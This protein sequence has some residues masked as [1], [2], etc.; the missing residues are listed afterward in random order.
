MVQT[1]APAKFGS[2]SPVEHDL[3]LPHALVAHWLE[4]PPA[5][6]EAAG[7]NPAEGTTE[8]ALREQHPRIERLNY[9]RP[10]IL[11]GRQRVQVHLPDALDRQSRIVHAE[12]VEQQHQQFF[13][14]LAAGTGLDAV[15]RAVQGG[16]KRRV[17][18]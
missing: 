14:H 5:K 1:R 11:Y 16:L 9:H 4:H 8:P 6:R 7:P 13:V 2:W 10:V 12:A 17:G 3:H 18:V 15:D